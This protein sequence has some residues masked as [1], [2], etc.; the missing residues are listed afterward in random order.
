ML[1][2][3]GERRVK[4]ATT[5]FV[6]PSADVIGQVVLGE[7]ASIWFN[8]VLR[9]DN[10]LIEIGA[11]TNVQDGAVIHTDPGFPVRLGEGVTVGH[12]AIVHGAQVGDYSLVGMQA[13][14]MNGAQIGQYCLVGAGALVTEGMQVPDGSLVLG[15]PAKTIKPLPAV[16]RE[17][18]E[19]S[20]QVYVQKAGWYLSEL[21]AC[22]SLPA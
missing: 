20:A 10:E 15:A 12:Q 14:I 3:L 6:A 9:G 7:Y 21:K 19:K 18:L 13:V 22:P 11:S 8:A 4:V 5:V 16:G 17:L 1:Y 2:S